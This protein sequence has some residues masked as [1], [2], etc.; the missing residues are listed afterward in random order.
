VSKTTPVD[1][2]GYYDREGET[3]K[4]LPD[5][6]P[7]EIMRVEFVERLLEGVSVASALDVGCGNGYLAS[8]LAARGAGQVAGV[9]FS[10]PRLKDG[11]KRFEHIRFSRASGTALPFADKSFDLITMVEVLEHI[12]ETLPALR[13]LARV[14]KKYILITVPY[15]GETLEITCPHCMKTHHFDGH[16][17]SFDEAGL[18]G[19]AREA[20]LR[21]RQIQTYTPYYPSQNPVLRRF[22]ALH[23][24]ARRL[25]VAARLKDSQQPKYLGL[26][27]EV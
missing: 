27:A 18:G 6:D 5:H 16:I 3:K 24:G 10:R 1:W 7:A 17:H 20:G 23:R 12:P 14:A 26:L 13:E 21:V 8:R 2:R 25:A 15:R 19:L 22:P 4:F 9:D 11:S